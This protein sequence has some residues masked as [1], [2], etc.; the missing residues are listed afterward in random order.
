VN[1]AGILCAMNRWMMLEFSRRTIEGLRAHT[2]FRL[3]L[4]PFRTF[5]E[6][7]VRKEV[8]KDRRVITR[9]AQ[10]LETG[11]EPGEADI[12]QLLQEAR[13]IDGVFLREALPFPITIGIPYN[14]IE[15]IRRERI[16]RLL[17]ASYRLL[18]QWE[19]TPQFRD[20]VSVLYDREQFNA[21]LHE[22][23][24]LYCQETRRLSYSFRMPMVLALARDS[25]MQLIYSTMEKV[26]TQLTKDLT[27]MVY[28]RPD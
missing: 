1:K 16:E 28:R 19:K 12:D 6:I 2:L 25:L 8:D 3:M 15:P 7:N 4:P 10:A 13:E 5:L 11:R 23:L 22:I 20:A 21:L 18:G 27:L 17:H 9:A 26:A 24:L 14:D